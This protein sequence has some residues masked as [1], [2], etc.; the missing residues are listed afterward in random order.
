MGHLI[1]AA[2][3]IKKLGASLK[4]WDRANGGFTWQTIKAHGGWV[5]LTGCWWSTALSCAGLVSCQQKHTRVKLSSYLS[6]KSR[7]ESSN[8]LLLNHILKFGMFSR[9]QCDPLSLAVSVIPRRTPFFLQNIKPDPLP[10]GIKQTPAL[11]PQL[12]SR[13]SPGQSACKVLLFGVCFCN[14][15]KVFISQVIHVFSFEIEKLY[16]C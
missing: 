16:H 12:P 8:S 6:K 3:G 15:P 9:R 1:Q 4:P 14:F 11:H 13:S 7:Q 2:T 10:R 5:L